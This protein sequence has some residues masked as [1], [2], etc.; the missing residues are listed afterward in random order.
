MVDLG[1]YI[2]INLNTGKLT[3]EELFTHVYVDELYESDHVCTS[4]KRL[5]VILDAKQEKSDLYKV[6][7]TQYQYLTTTQRK[8]LL[9]SL[10]RFNE[11]FD[12]TLGT[13]KID[14]V[15]FRLK[16]DMKPICS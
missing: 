11:L 9:K 3:P 13:W 15:Y 1:M 14:S 16:E 4:T 12:G 10:Q 8:E 5:R 7:E 6:M 2:L